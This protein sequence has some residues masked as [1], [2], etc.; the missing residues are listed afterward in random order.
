MDEGLFSTELLTAAAA[1]FKSRPLPAGK[2]VRELEPN[3]TLFHLEYADGLKASV[4]TLKGAFVDWSAAWQT[5]AGET[6]A[7]CFWTQE[8]RPFMHFGFQLRGIEQMI[9]SGRPAWPAERTLLVSGAL[10]SLLQSR[11]RSGETLPTPQL[12][13]KYRTDWDW[14]SPP[15]PPPNRPLNGE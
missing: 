15:P 6:T 12:N 9:H 3:P 2:T 1:K 11:K 14:Q 5:A 13:V 4:V 7:T 8:A 10:D